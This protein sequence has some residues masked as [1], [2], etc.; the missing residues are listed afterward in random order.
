MMWRSYRV[1]YLFF[2]CYGLSTGHHVRVS[3]DA[4][5]W[6][7][8]RLCL[9]KRERLIFNNGGSDLDLHFFT[10]VIRTPVRNLE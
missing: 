9:M 10:R 1:R 2:T 7:E 5:G 8:T 3:I 6:G 4:S